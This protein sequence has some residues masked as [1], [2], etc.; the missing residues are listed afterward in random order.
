MRLRIE[1]VALGLVV[2]TVVP[3]TAF[4]LAPRL[5]WLVLWL[6]C[7]TAALQAPTQV[8]L[9]NGGHPTRVIVLLGVLTVPGSAGYGLLVLPRHLAR[10]RPR[11]TTGERPSSRTRSAA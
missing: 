6:G 7:T 8:L 1:R 11:R 4:K 3:Y 9:A 2:L 10:L 5:T